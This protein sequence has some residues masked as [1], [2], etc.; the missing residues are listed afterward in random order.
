[1]GNLD[2]VFVERFGPNVDAIFRDVAHP[3]SGDSQ[4][5]EP[6][7]NLFFPFTR[8]KSWFDGHSFATGLFPFATGKSQESSS[9]AANCYY[10]AYLWSLVRHGRH[11]NSDLTDFARLLLSMEIRSA[12]TYWH[13]V[14]PT[15]SNISNATQIY[16]IDF[17]E[18]YMVGNVGMLDVTATTWFGNDPLYVHLI[19]VL[20]ISAVTGILFEKDYVKYQYPFLM[21]SRESVEMAWRGY[22]VSIQA[23]ID[24]DQAWEEAQDLQSYQLDATLSKSQ[25]LY[26]ISQ[27]PN[28]TSPSIDTGGTN[29][30]NYTNNQGS[31]LCHSYPECTAAGL[32]GSC[33]PTESNMMLDCCT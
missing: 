16:N 19:N 8:H 28:F 21:E 7:G 4:D 13:M 24:P 1:M 32:T 18:N 26:W 12:K 15:A 6:G 29:N 25:V 27:R 9:E 23:I 5:V 22:A 31:S 14:P 11:S 17:Q 33:C 2:P 3:L 20:P 30:A 10:G